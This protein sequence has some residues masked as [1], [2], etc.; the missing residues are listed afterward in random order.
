MNLHRLNLTGW[1]L[2]GLI[3]GVITGLVFGDLLSFL[4]PVAEAFVKIWQIT[5][6][7]TV[8]LSLIV[9]IG[10][11]KRDTA[12]AVALKAFLVMLLFWV[13]G[14]LILFSFQFSFPPREAA[15]FF[16]IPDQSVSAEISFIDLFIPSN[17]FTALSEGWI[18]AIVIF[19]LFLGLGLMLDDGS[20]PVIS[21]LRTVQGAFFR[22]TKLLSITFPVGTFVV[23]AR[24][25]G[26][27]DLETILE[28]QVL[29][30]STAVACILLCFVVIPLLVTCFTPYRYR[31]VISAASRAVILGLSTGSEIIL[32][33]LISEGITKIFVGQDPGPAL[34]G[35]G[36]EAD[37]PAEPPPAHGSEEEK[38]ESADR[39]VRAYSDI[40]V[41]VGYTFPLLGKLVPFIFIFFVAWLYQNPLDLSRQIQLALLG[42]PTLFGSAKSAVPSLLEYMHLPLDAYNLYLSTGV[43][44]SRLM[45]AL[46]AMSIFAFSVISIALATDQARLNKKR[47]VI[48]V[49]VVLLLIVA[50]ITGLKAGFSS[51]LAG[52]YHGGDLISQIELPPAPDGRALDEVVNTTVYLRPEDVPVPAAYDPGGG[53]T[54]RR[55]RERG[56]LRVGY[57]SNCMPFSFF[58]GKGQLVGYDIEM[59]YDLARAIRVSRI[60]FVP[61]NGDTL[62]GSLNTGYCDIVMSSVIVT[63]DRL[64]EMKFTDPYIAVHMAFVVPDGQ[65]DKYTELET[66][67]SMDG[68]RMAVFNHTALADVAPRLFPGAEIVP[69]DSREEFFTG[70]RADVLFVAAEEGYPMTMLYPFYDVAIVRPGSAFPVMYAYPVAA[71]SSESFLSSLNYWIRV[72]KEYGELDRKYDYWILVKIPHL[73][74]PRWSVVRNVLHWVT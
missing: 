7:P 69:I 67:K 53:D 1:M 64:T 59:A 22:M 55:I 9:G 60:E 25:A 4:T 74:E 28:L 61:V 63:A 66:V 44:R 31:D 35:S 45:A 56:A 24:A 48:T 39:S 58:N 47:L 10:S 16:S 36:N 43:L 14:I 65:K 30:V 50:V 52:T 11:L 38:R 73:A 62:A 23:T 17:P 5:I 42:I 21:L 27:L 12:R 40:L 54:V 32:L 57:N 33:P 49:L 37:M 51:L 19:S 20:G 70:H 6:L 41:P 68:L 72:E 2:L 13:I 18:P 71:N 3:L 29:V 46:T 15:S 8:M 26:T 34:R